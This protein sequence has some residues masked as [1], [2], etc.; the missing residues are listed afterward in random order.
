MAAGRRAWVWTFSCNT[1][2]PGG[3]LAD[4]DRD[5]GA[6]SALLGA[7]LEHAHLSAQ[8][9]QGAVCNHALVD[10]HP[11]ADTLPRS[12]I[13]VCCMAR[14]ALSRS[15]SSTQALE[16]PALRT[17]VSENQYANKCYFWGWVAN[18][19]KWSYVLDLINVNWLFGVLISAQYAHFA[20]SIRRADCMNPVCY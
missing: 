11:R 12:V 2:E 6:R 8:Q 14:S 1:R 17:A 4:F 10:I 16:S 20:I 18:C 13:S 9:F 15:M 5:V 7:L 19:C 3:Q